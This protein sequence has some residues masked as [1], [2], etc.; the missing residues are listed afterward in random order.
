MRVPGLALLRFAAVGLLILGAVAA[1]GQ[2]R[3]QAGDTAPPDT[4]LTVAPGVPDPRFPLPVSDDVNPIFEFTGSD[5]VTL[6][7]ALIFECQ[8]DGGGW[9]P[10][11]S[12]TQ[13]LSLAY[14]VHTFGVR[15]IDGA[16]NIDPT[17]AGW[18]WD[19]RP[20]CEGVFATRWGTPGADLING[21]DITDVI[22][23]LGGN[24]VIN[25][26]AGNDMICGDGGRDQIDGGP[27]TDRVF[28]GAGNDTI[29]GG[30]GKD[31]LGG[32]GGDD[33]IT[34]LSGTSIMN[35]DAGNDVLTSGITADTLTGGGGDDILNGGGGQ[36]ALNGE[37]GNDTLNG[38]DGP[39]ILSGGAGAD[40]FNG[41]AG[42]DLFNDFSPAEGDTNP[43]G[44]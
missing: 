16:G 2:A 40:L 26:L 44:T 15:A 33:T 38:G 39:D 19:L 6:P 21:T 14:A 30:D 23:G 29:T 11:S 24:D 37:A 9:A 32:D 35:G 8:L 18:M 13:Y 17:P 3:A 25:G 4:I 22:V 12:P 10:C 31:I 43:S 42:R 34:D 28:G 41:G 27:G 7:E 20:A 36:D 1:P 5:D